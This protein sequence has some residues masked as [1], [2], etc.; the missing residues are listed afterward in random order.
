[1]SLA[2]VSPTDM[3]E[4]RT[5]IQLFAKGAPALECIRSHYIPE[6]TGVCDLTGAKEQDEIFVL[7][8]RAGSTIKVSARAMQIIANILDI[9]G[10]DQWYAHLREQRRAVRER[11]IEETRRQEEERKA[12]ARTVVLRKKSP[13][14]PLQG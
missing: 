12:S 4:Y 2:Y 9:N 11:T 14:R 3:N 8:N 10:A 7:A 5:R 1:M 13:N 6:H